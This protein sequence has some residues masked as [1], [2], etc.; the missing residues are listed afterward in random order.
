MD[1][2]RRETNPEPPSSV[3]RA[4]LLSGRM[5]GLADLV[6]VLATGELTCLIQ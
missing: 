6:S 5:E 1:P 2:H 3:E 4:W